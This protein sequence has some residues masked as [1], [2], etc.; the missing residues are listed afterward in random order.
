MGTETWDKDYISIH[1]REWIWYQEEAASKRLGKE[2]PLE[3]TIS[4]LKFPMGF[5]G[6]SDGKGS[7]CNAG[8]LGLISGLGRRPGEG[9]DYPFQYSCLENPTDRGAWRAIIHGIPK[10]QT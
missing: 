9:N 6:D 4:Y 3:G 7:T 5:P 1:T 8:D 10:S 2:V